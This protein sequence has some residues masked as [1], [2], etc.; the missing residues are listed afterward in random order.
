VS[1]LGGCLLQLVGAT[2][3]SLEK[4]RRQLP[5]ELQVKATGAGAGAGAY[6]CSA[7]HVVSACIAAHTSKTREGGGW[8]STSL[9]VYS[10]AQ[11]RPYPDR[12]GTGDSEGPVDANA[13]S[14]F[15]SQSRVSVS[16]LGLE[17]R[18]THS[19]SYLAPDNCLQPC[20][21]LHFSVS[22]SGPD[23]Q[24]S[25]LQT[26]ISILALPRLA[27]S[28]SNLFFLTNKHKNKHIYTILHLHLHQHQNTRSGQPTASRPTTFCAVGVTTRPLCDASNDCLFVAT[29]RAT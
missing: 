27:S 19:T 13:D 23:L 20:G 4:C 8:L 29:T 28:C 2:Q 21:R 12:P 24:L 5:L 6:V 15:Q 7:Y 10:T 18:S 17:S 1:A 22:K 9:D 26:R 16:S 11:P 14:G 3:L 25:H